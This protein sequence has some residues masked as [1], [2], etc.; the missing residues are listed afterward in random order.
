MVMSSN[1]PEKLDK[2]LVRPGRIDMTLEFKKLTRENVNNLY[3]L[4][5]G[6]SI[7]DSVY[8]RMKDRALTQADIG[9]LFSSRNLKKIHS[10]LG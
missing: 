7:P 5:F 9:L 4:W 2:A 1:H 10:A 8:A 6:R 3:K